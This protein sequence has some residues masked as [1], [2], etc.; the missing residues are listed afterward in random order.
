[1]QNDIV[2]GVEQGG[3]VSRYPKVSMSASMP[4]ALYSQNACH[5]DRVSGQFAETKGRI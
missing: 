1:M 3:V 5:S 4:P 2:F